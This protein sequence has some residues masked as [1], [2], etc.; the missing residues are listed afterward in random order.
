MSRNVSGMLKDWL[1]N[2]TN[3]VSGLSFLYIS[4]QPVSL[5]MVTGTR[6]DNVWRTNML[7]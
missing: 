7:M 2:D 5:H 6:Y 3:R 4:I 1:V